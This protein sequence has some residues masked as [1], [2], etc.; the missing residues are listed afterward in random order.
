MV[1]RSR[2]VRIDF[3]YLCD[4][5]EKHYLME[6]RYVNNRKVAGLRSASSVRGY[7]KVFRNYFGRQKLRVK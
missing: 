4:F 3:N 7:I 1:V 2:S 6:A 5:Y